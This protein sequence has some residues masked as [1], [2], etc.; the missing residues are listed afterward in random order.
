M[1]N[2]VGLL[3]T[4]FSSNYSLLLLSSSD[5]LNPRTSVIVTDKLSRGAV[6]LSFNLSAR[7][8]FIDFLFHLEW[9]EKVVGSDY[10]LYRPCFVLPTGE[11]VDLH[12]LLLL[13]TTTT[14]TATAGVVPVGG[15]GGSGTT[16]T[17]NTTSS[18][19]TT[20]TSNTTSVTLAGVPIGRGS[21]S[22]TGSKVAVAPPAATT[23]PPPPTPTSILHTAISSPLLDGHRSPLRKLS[24]FFSSSFI[25]SDNT[26]PRSTSLPTTSNTT[27]SHHPGSGATMT[28]QEALDI[29]RLL[30]VLVCATFP[31][32]LESEECNRWLQGTRAGGGGDG[33]GVAGGGGFT[34]ADLLS[35]S[36]DPR[37]PPPPAT[38]QGRGGG[39]GGG[40]AGGGGGRR[41]FDPSPALFAEADSLE[42]D[43]SVFESF[44]LRHPSQRYHHGRAV[45][46]GGGGGG[47]PTLF[48]SASDEQL[49]VGSRQKEIILPEVAAAS[50]AA[51]GGLRCRSRS[52]SGTTTTTHCYT[53]TVVN[54]IYPATTT[55]TMDR[56]K[57]VLTPVEEGS[58]PR[59]VVLPT[60]EGGGGAGAGGVDLLPGGVEG[61]V[62]VAGGGGGGVATTTTPSSS[63]TTTATPSSSTTTTTSTPHDQIDEAIAS[64]LA[65][66]HHLQHCLSNLLPSTSHTVLTTLLS[67][68][69][70]LPHTLHY[71][72]HLPV[73]LSI[74]TA[75]VQGFPLCYV[76]QAF[77]N[78][79]G[80]SYYDAVGKRCSSLLH[81]TDMTEGV[82]VAR[83]AFA[84]K[85]KASCTKVM[86]TNKKKNGQVFLN[87]LT[88]RT[89][90][91]RVGR[92]KFVLAAQLEY[93]SATT[94]NTT[95]PTST[96]TS[97]TTSASSPTST[98]TT[99][100]SGMEEV[101]KQLE[102]IDMTL[103]LLAAMLH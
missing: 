88:M 21:S 53:H 57:S 11:R 36:V 86:I 95:S 48:S 2:S 84:L 98:S 7:Q 16:T 82:Q 5:I 60:E 20:T 41:R 55:T 74:S 44:R 85:M 35:Q 92:L 101:E 18:I 102:L 45:A 29:E 99:T 38:T 19:T 22:S 73:S 72:Y 100:S 1:G 23:S 52:F 10:S 14:S 69:H 34:S 12:L 68:D 47:P 89:V 8:A 3:S 4:L 103:S 93:P 61:E 59:V 67:N 80:Y 27:S 65:R 62:V 15:G 50:G 25:P 13:T 66:V 71:F 30:P 37:S 46:G 28:I 39:G 9:V 75:E 43:N 76:N 64:G 51:G 40:G 24:A 58:V 49:L 83:L 42:D 54:G 97:N 78:L 17:S 91:D 77:T 94:S 33:G 63:T 70:W 79:T 56:S 26:L 96:S 87:A 31:F 6:L 32:F 81:H 90:V